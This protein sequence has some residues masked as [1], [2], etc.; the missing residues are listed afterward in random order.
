M[1][2]T[3][4]LAVAALAPGISA[5]ANLYQQ[6]KLHC[7]RLGFYRSHHDRWR[8][9][10]LRKHKLCIWRILFCGQRLYVQK[11]TMSNPTT[12]LMSERLLAV[13]ARCWLRPFCYRYYR[14]G[15]DYVQD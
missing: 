7:N 13:F 5:Q 6:C 10:I 12:I 11:A 1:R 3:S 2:G 14:S 9:W 4:F 15:P 8:Y